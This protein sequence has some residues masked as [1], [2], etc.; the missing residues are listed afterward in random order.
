M[1]VDV[2]S[3]LYSALLNLRRLQRPLQAC[4][5]LPSG[6]ASIP[7]AAFPLN[8]HVLFLQSN[9][10]LYVASEEPMTL[11]REFAHLSQDIRSSDSCFSACSTR[12]SGSNNI[13]QSPLSDFSQTVGLSQPSIHVSSSCS[14]SCSQ[15]S[16]DIISSQVVSQK[17]SMSQAKIEPDCSPKSV[18]CVSSQQQQRQYHL[19]QQ[20]QQLTDCTISPTISFNAPVKL[21][22]T[23]DVYPLQTAP[24]DCED[25]PPNSLAPCLPLTT[26]NSVSTTVSAAA[27]GGEYVDDEDWL[28]RMKTQEMHRRGS[29]KPSAKRG[30]S[31]SRSSKKKEVLKLKVSMQLIRAD[32]VGI[33]VQHALSHT[34]LTS[35]TSFTS[36]SSSSSSHT[37]VSGGISFTFEVDSLL[38]VP[39]L[40][41]L[42]GKKTQ[43]HVLTFVKEFVRSM[44]TGVW[45]VEHHMWCCALSEQ[46]KFVEGLMEYED[47][48][49]GYLELEVCRASLEINRLLENTTPPQWFR[50]E[51]QPEERWSCR[52]ASSDESACE[53]VSLG[54]FSYWDCY[55]AVP[56]LLWDAL[57]PFQRQAVEFGVRR[58]GR[59]LIADEMGLGK[60]LQAICMVCVFH[61]DWPLLIVCPASLKF[62]WKAELLQWLPFLNETMIHVVSS[63][64]SGLVASHGRTRVTIA[65][66]ELM[67][68]YEAEALALD[69]N[70]IICDESHY[71]KNPT[72]SRTKALVPVLK[73]SRRVVM[74][75]GTPAL[76][77]PIELFPQI[78]CI[79]PGFFGTIEA[80]GYMYCGGV[81]G[82]W[83]MEY[84][85]AEM[86]VQLHTLLKKFV[87]IR[88]LKSEALPELRPKKRTAV[89]ANLYGHQSF[90][91]C[92]KP[93]ELR[94]LLEHL[95]ASKE[96]DGEAEPK[97]G[98]N[99]AHFL[100]LFMQ[101]GKMK[102]PIVLQY[103]E[104]QLATSSQFLVFAHH[105]AVMDGIE[106]LLINLGVEYI[107]I[108]GSTSPQL[109]QE[110]VGLFQSNPQIRV[111]VLSLT[112]ASTGLTLTAAN[113]VVFA[114]LYWTPSLLLQA[115][116]RVHRIGQS[117]DVL[118]SYIIA[119]NTLDDLMW[120]VLVSKLKVL[121]SALD[122][123]VQTM[124]FVE[125]NG[126]SQ[127]N[128]S[129]FLKLD[130]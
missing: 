80:F 126:D 69:F 104:R 39:E 82:R 116:D 86:L 3:P 51:A 45:D 14:S 1:A 102:L 84:R 29:A 20:Q 21:E 113:L 30:R 95:A 41:A 17:N 72:A 128:D 117:R 92:T 91:L 99:R 53:C 88:R 112:A 60:T 26:L 97:W 34:T 9:P 76:S 120:P 81:K 47:N 68:K 103:I 77:F 58:G 40:R 107:R 4:T 2:P 65:S 70:A 122:G 42:E 12:M 125:I 121:G 48:S 111:A 6:D 66:Y 115:E 33:T 11:K 96:E 23:F 71:L 15:L 54:Q 52:C 44:E 123:E 93:D 94:P 59:V 43:L 75:S 74:L 89:M 118:I 108:D 56:E 124:E 19:N 5:S 25:I 28:V 100:D 10:S 109:R 13:N 37:L 62:N 50:H 98:G 22:S 7:V 106:H 67:T 31:G 127:P 114:E 73:K 46:D 79:M 8:Q 64:Q 101:T 61:Q 57:R 130:S 55:D 38:T 18:L 78:D 16:C 32:T 36:S 85:G 49:N 110:R 83:G 90:E 87:M 119:M 105:R 35:P 24:E 27:A 63:G 129:R